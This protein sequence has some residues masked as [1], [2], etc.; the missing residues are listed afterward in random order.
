MQLEVIDFEFS[1]YYSTGSIT[2]K[3]ED[4]VF[5]IEQ[6]DGVHKEYRSKKSDDHILT[7]EEANINRMLHQ[8]TCSIEEE[9]C[10]WSKTKQMHWVAYD[11]EEINYDEN[12]DPIAD[13]DH[14][15]MWL[16][17]KEFKDY[18]RDNQVQEF[19]TNVDDFNNAVIEYINN[20]LETERDQ[21]IYDLKFGAGTIIETPGTITCI[22]DRC[23]MK[24]GEE[25][26]CIIIGE[27]VG[28]CVERVLVVDGRYA[29]CVINDKFSIVCVGEEDDASIEKTYEGFNMINDAIKDMHDMTE[30][31]LL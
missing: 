12:G 19:L 26:Y 10:G 22:Y 3:C 29:L 8:A 4:R 7:D 27:R 1:G 28:E 18:I 14:E 21:I 31:E 11:Y 9:F 13:E 16:N 23:R 30:E 17:G 5:Q 25:D 2:V 15:V 6:I 20:I 24:D